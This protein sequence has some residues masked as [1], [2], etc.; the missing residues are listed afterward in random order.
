MGLNELCTA[1]WKIFACVLAPIQV[2][3]MYY[4]K[5]DNGQYHLHIFPL[6]A[7]HSFIDADEKA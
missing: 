6:C 2:M 3:L 4:L 5:T 7:Q 1:D